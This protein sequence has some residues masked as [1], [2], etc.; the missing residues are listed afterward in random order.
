LKAA[1]LYLVIGGLWILLSDRILA[2]I[3]LDPARYARLQTLKGW[4]FVLVTAAIAYVVVRSRLQEAVAFAELAADRESQYRRIVETANEGIWIIDQHAATTF[5][6]QQMADMLGY[7]VAEMVG[8]SIFTFVS[9]RDR[10]RAAENL[11]RRR[12][13]LA[14]RLTFRFVRRDGATIWAVLNTSPI[15]AEEGTY[16]GSLAMVSDITKRKEVQEEREKL[17]Q[18]LGE[19]AREVQKI[20]DTVPDGLFLLSADRQVSL[21][22]PVADEYLAELVDNGPDRLDRLG[23][24]PVAELLTPP[25]KGQWHEI[26]CKGH[27]FEVIARSTD[28]D[29]KPA[30]WVVLLRDVTERRNV[31]DL[32]RRQERL[33]AIGQLAAGIAHD[34]NNIMSVIVL[35]TDMLLRTPDLSEEVNERIQTVSNQAKEATYLIQQILDF[36]RA[37]VLEQVALDL[38]PFVSGIVQLMHRMLPESIQIDFVYDKDDYVISADPTRIQQ[39][40]M[41]LLINARDAMPQGG[42]ITIRLDRVRVGHQ[43]GAPLHTMEKGDWVHISVTDTGSGMDPDTLARIFDPFFSTKPAGRGTGLGLAQVYGIVKQHAGE[44]DVTSELGGGTIFD[45][46]LPMHPAS[47]IVVSEDRVESV[48]LGQSETV[49]LVEDDPVVL[50]SLTEGLRSLNYKVLQAD[51][52]QAA[53]SLLQ[54]HDGEISLVLS[55]FVM[56]QMG[57]RALLAVVRRQYPKVPMVMLTGHPLDRELDELLSE[58]L[59]DWLLKP[60]PLEKLAAVIARVIAE[61]AAE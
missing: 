52:G 31:Q 54:A 8:Q 29:S 37:S 4:L 46:Y 60:P 24:K 42:T 20:V 32:A 61:H 21:T 34:F 45:I 39:V 12:A 25:P 22:N 47:E 36:A 43:G 51:D 49:L 50:A 9:E 53:L 41:N 57:G 7:T 55:D 33:S 5:V 56:P 26:R 58:G 35:Y 48:T 59:S 16:L 28:R 17:V 13:R 27:V 44:I 3:V 2:W 11:A 15:K 6:N 18:R 40:I 10:P 19:H 38:V 30:N 1:V 14:E 23:N